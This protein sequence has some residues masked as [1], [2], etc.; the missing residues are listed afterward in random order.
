MPAERRGCWSRCPA[1]SPLPGA[2]EE[3]VTYS[4]GRAQTSLSMVTASSYT[5]C[6]AHMHSCT[7][8]SSSSEVH[9]CQA[10]PMLSATEMGQEHWLGASGLH[11]PKE[12]C[13]IG[14]PVQRFAGFL[15][16]L[17]D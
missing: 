12:G 9:H 17:Q 6:H 7:W 14:F 1:L 16:C 3:Q 8:V 5:S 2:V 11:L 15:D 4:A 10:C 13:K